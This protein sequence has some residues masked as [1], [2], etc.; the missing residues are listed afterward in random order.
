MCFLSP[1]E[2]ILKLG[3]KLAAQLVFED[4]YLKTINLL[5]EMLGTHNLGVQMEMIFLFPYEKQRTILTQ[6]EVQTQN[7]SRSDPV[8][9]TPVCSQTEITGSGRNF[10][11]TIVWT[12][13]WRWSDQR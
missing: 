5:T 12:M 2:A 10:E 4:K 6:V 11:R 8:E 7:F 9:C 1:K 3:N 13:V